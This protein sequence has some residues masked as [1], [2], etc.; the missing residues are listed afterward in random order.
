MPRWLLCERSRSQTIQR[1]HHEGHGSA[2]NKI[3]A[4]DLNAGQANDFVVTRYLAA[5]PL[6]EIPSTL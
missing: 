4:I 2:T 3:S 6:G 1:G 5:N